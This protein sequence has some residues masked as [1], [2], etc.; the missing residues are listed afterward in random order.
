MVLFVSHCWS[1]VWGHPVHFAKFL[2]SRF[3]KA[4]SPTTFIEFQADFRESI[5][6]RGKYRSL[7]FLAIC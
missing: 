1:S 3:S 6:N 7:P 5:C 2:I 4:T